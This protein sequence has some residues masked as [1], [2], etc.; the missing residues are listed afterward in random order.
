MKEENKDKETRL[1]DNAFKL[2]TKK[3][4]KRYINSRNS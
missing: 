4:C 3:R 2:F 1:L